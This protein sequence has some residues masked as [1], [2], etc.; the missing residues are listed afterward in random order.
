MRLSLIAAGAATLLIAGAALTPS[1][2]HAA[3]FNCRFARLPDERAICA[4]TGLNDQ[5]VRMAL[6][7]DI[8]RRL[9]PMGTRGAIM[10]RQVAWLRQRR[11]CGGDRNCIGRAYN[12]R[13]AELNQVMERVYRQGPF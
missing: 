3:S 9:V 6:L 12:M 1:H 2:S 10:D 7:Y 13:I 5:D 4:D 11:S 8:T